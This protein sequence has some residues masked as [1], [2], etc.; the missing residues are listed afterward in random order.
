MAEIYRQHRQIVD[1]D[2]VRVAFEEGWGLVRASN[3]QP[4]LVMRFEASNKELLE[5]YKNEVEQI[6][7]QAKKELGI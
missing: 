4:I 3:T 7:E 6:V 1:V 2:G 5:K